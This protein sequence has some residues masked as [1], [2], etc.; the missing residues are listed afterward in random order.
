V[1]LNSGCICEVRAKAFVASFESGRGVE[2]Q[3]FTIDNTD[4]SK[5]AGEER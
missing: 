2:L 1:T 5:E 3:N 4:L